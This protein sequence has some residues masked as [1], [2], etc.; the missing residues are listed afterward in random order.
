[1]AG[2]ERL[3]VECG[4]GSIADGALTMQVSRLV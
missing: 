3:W 1:V 4:H 2:K